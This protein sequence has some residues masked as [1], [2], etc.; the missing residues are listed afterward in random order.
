MYCRVLVKKCPAYLINSVEIYWVISFSRTV[1][2]NKNLGRIRAL[3]W[4]LII[5]YQN[6]NNKNENLTRPR[7]DLTLNAW[8][9]GYHYLGVLINNFCY[10]KSQ[11]RITK[12]FFLVDLRNKLNSLTCRFL[13]GSS[14]SITIHNA[15][16]SRIICL[17]KTDVLVLS[18]S[19]FLM[20]RTQQKTPMPDN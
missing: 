11:E 15:T 10:G 17:T 1:F 4:Y 19:Q 3:S 9:P 2:T 14:I 20:K 8:A 12:G 6:H 13:Q 7:E 5:A 16:T 18:N